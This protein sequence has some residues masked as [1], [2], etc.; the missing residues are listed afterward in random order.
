[1]KQIN[2]TTCL[3]QTACVI[4]IMLFHGLSGAETNRPEA[5]LLNHDLSIV[6]V[7]EKSRITAKDTITLPSDSTPEIRFLLHPGLNP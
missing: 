3:I 2:K 4:L 6:L 7:P 5:E 1:M